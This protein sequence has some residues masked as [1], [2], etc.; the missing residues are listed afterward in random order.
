MIFRAARAQIERLA[1]DPELAH[2]A[3]GA[4]PGL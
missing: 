4:L 3:T 2:I 1:A